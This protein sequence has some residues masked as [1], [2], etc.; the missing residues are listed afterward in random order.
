MK[1]FAAVFAILALLPAAGSAQR[2]RGMGGG[3]RG[4]GGRIGEGMD[5]H[6]A[7]LVFTA[8]LNLTDT[9]QQQLG[10]AFDAAV[11]SAAPLNTQ[12]E[13]GKTALFEAIKS[14]K[15]QE[16]IKAL[17]DQQT[18][19]MSQLLSLET[20][21][22]SKMCALL[23]SDQKAQVDDTMFTDIVQFLGNARVPV[24]EPWQPAATPP[25]PGASTP[26]T[27]SPTQ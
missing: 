13:S 22:F 4:G 12:I 9:Q 21:T 3:M 26:G 20:Q 16:Q 6:T 15:T 27:P 5:E 8:L 17:T 24:A 25:A 11:K 18:S 7:L 19:L 10:T 14:G 1:R 2:G 23:T